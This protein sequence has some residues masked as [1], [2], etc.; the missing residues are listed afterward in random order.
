MRKFHTTKMACLGWSLVMLLMGSDPGLAID[1]CP[2]AWISAKISARLVV[3]MGAAG[4][5]I[6]P[7]TEVCVVTLRGCV[8]TKEQRK[9]AIATA[10]KVEKVK[11][12][13]DKLKTCEE[14]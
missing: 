11:V 9:T 2:D 4:G 8:K 5:R 6:N 13:I 7:D 14:D 1:D 12:V 10:R 3:K